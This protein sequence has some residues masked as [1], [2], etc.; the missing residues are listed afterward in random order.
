MYRIKVFYIT[1]YRSSN[2]PRAIVGHR[3]QYYLKLNKTLLQTS[4]SER[5]KWNPV[6]KYCKYDRGSR[7]NS[8][9]YHKMDKFWHCQLKRTK[10]LNIYV[11]LLYWRLQLALGGAQGYWPIPPLWPWVYYFLIDKILA[12]KKCSC[13]R[14]KEFR[15]LFKGLISYFTC[16]P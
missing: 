1:T 12:K 16:E 4:C 10:N 14:I 7:K 5:F 6:K 9:N 3:G 13:K 2:L 11:S 8:R 15:T